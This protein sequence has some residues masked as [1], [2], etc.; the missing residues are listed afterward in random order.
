[1]RAFIRSMLVRFAV[2]GKSKLLTLGV[3]TVGRQITALHVGKESADG[4]VMDVGT[5][6]RNAR[7]AAGLSLEQISHNTKIQ[8]AK[9]EALEANA[10]DQ[11]PHGIYLEGIV[12]AYAAEVGV[13][14]N[15]LVNALDAELAA[16][17]T[18]HIDATAAYDLDT[19]APEAGVESEP[20]SA[21]IPPAS[22]ATLL[23]TAPATIE[24][25]ASAE[26]AV[27]RRHGATRRRARRRRAA[28][29][30][31]AALALCASFGLGW[32]LYKTSRP[33]PDAQRAAVPAVSRD[34]V[35][36]GAADDSRSSS[37]RKP[38]NDV[39]ADPVAASD[40][41]PPDMRA[42]QT[43]DEARGTAAAPD[44]RAGSAAASTD[45]AA[46]AVSSATPA[47]ADFTGI[48]RLETEVVSSSVGN[49][50][51]LQ[52][53]YHLQLDQQGSEISGNGE[54]ISENGRALAAAARTAIAV[55]GTVNGNQ[56][57]LTFTERGAR[58]SSQGALVLQRD[59]DGTLRGRFSSDAAKSSGLAQLRR[60][61]G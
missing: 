26:R 45:A 59:D 24:A 50:K 9:L 39:A 55:R 52:L 48:W 15:Q 7:R 20:P 34:A 12:R 40:S 14:A 16:R 60:P 33:F 19:F 11:L 23:A 32:Y 4:S 17:P 2:E 54:K 56:L 47:P 49:F 35:R 37:D 10:F 6:L 57:A 46:S 43:P 36:A 61:Q 27:P 28:G 1:M 25:P 3:A 18:R 41:A 31:L 13:D 51:G 30:A 21:T 8:V 44:A 22:R 58:R 5:E 42:S 38:V 29:V 53:G